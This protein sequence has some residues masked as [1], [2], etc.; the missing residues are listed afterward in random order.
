MGSVALDS[1]ETPFGSASRVVGGAATYFGVAAA[2][3]T[4][5]RLVGV[6]GDDFDDER[7]QIFEG[8]RID[9]AGLQRVAG[10]TFRW[11][12]K[13]SY[14]LN[15]RETIYTFLNVFE[16][17]R[18]TIPLAYRSSPFV[19][20]GNIH[21]AL[22]LDVLDQVESPRL[23]AADTMN[24]WIERAPEELRKVLTRI[25]ALVINDAEARQLSGEANLVKAVRAIQAMGPKLLIIKRGE[26]GV[27]MTR[28]DGFFAVPGLPLEDVYDPTGAGDTFG[29]GF[30]GY[31]AGSPEVADDSLAR[32]VIAGSTMASFSVE[33]FGLDRLLTVTPEDVQRRFQ[34]FKRLTHFEAL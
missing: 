2:H 5:V 31:L 20:L 32:A 7:M 19:F 6:V 27:L 11:K 21:P 28:G 13:Y 12:G 25:D 29:G 26:H 33:A 9:L 24:Y 18:P 17:F 15:D 23:V 4:D 14:D 1:I 22:Q 30:L 34:E 10:D 8:R 3:F 16:E